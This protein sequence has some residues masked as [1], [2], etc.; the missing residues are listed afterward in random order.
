MLVTVIGA[1]LAVLAAVPHANGQT[2]NT[3]APSGEITSDSYFYGDSPPVYPSPHVK[4]LYIFLFLHAWSSNSI[5]VTIFFV[6]PNSKRFGPRYHSLTKIITLIAGNS[7]IDIKQ[8]R[9]LLNQFAYIIRQL[10]IRKLGMS[11]RDVEI[12]S[13][14]DKK[15]LFEYNRAS[16]EMVDSCMRHLIY[17]VVH[18]QPTM[19][20]QSD[21]TEGMYID[22]RRFD[23]MGIEPRSEFGFGLSYTIFEYSRLSISKP[24]STKGALG[25]YPTGPTLPGGYADLWDEIIEVA[26]T[27]T[28][29]FMAGAE[30]AQLYL[31]IP[32]PKGNSV[33]PTPIRQLQGYDKPFIDAGKSATV[34]FSLTRRDLS[35]WDVVAQA[36]EV[37]GEIMLIPLPTFCPFAL[38]SFALLIPVAYIL[39]AES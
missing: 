13:P 26:V 35:I 8:T 16:P 31:G 22:Y 19:F 10:S 29:G 39:Y 33:P 17:H 36:W 15:E 32:S 34:I 2:T 20:P 24:S 38:M 18:E 5:T 11:V 3:S 14:Q 1:G 37:L 4:L 7:S 9:R 23:Q 27:I 12:I 6:T 28:K 21:F 30:V 25:P